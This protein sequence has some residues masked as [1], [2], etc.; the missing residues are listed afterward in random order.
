L[1]SIFS[2]DKNANTTPEGTSYLLPFQNI[3]SRATLHV[4][5]FFPSDLADFAVPCPKP[6]EFDVLSDPGDSQDESGADTL[7]IDAGS[8][9]ESERRWEWRFGLKLQDA[10]GHRKEEVATMDVFIA[11]QD[12]ECLLKLDAVE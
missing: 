5:D 6:S 2:N 7:S 3:K 8:E 11:G 9:T 1:S 4:T 12:A 10:M